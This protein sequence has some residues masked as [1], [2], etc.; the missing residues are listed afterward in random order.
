MMAG[1]EEQS[2]PSERHLQPSR[3]ARTQALCSAGRVR[4]VLRSGY[5]ERDSLSGGAEQCCEAISVN[6][7]E[8]ATAQP[9]LG[10]TGEPEVDR[11]RNAERPRSLANPAHDPGHIVELP[12][13]R[14]IG[15]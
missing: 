1:R 14:G 2:G 3:H 11:A 12:G 6:V 15:K 10:V 7:H 5:G 8:L 9:E 13:F 4:D